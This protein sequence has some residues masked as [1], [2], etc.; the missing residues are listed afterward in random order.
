MFLSLGTGGGSA[1]GTVTFHSN[2]VTISD[3][4]WSSNQITGGSQSFGAV[5]VFTNAP[6]ALISAKYIQ[7]YNSKFM[8]N[9]ATAGHGSIAGSSLSGCLSLNSYGDRTD[10]QIINCTFTNN[11][12]IGGNGSTTSGEGRAGALDLQLTSES[13]TKI[14]NS[15]FYGNRARAGNIN[16]SS[17]SSGT[18]HGGAIAAQLN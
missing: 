12:S 9:M 16:L 3:C 13:S 2:N 10:F 8:D 1:S 17:G 14:I 15:T 7:I 5:G 18:C 6:G 4:L 11:T